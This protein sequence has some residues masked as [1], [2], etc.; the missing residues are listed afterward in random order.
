MTKDSGLR[1]GVQRDLRGKFLEVHR[2]QD[3]PAAQVIREFMRDY[4][5]HHGRST[6]LAVRQMPATS[7]NAKD[8][9]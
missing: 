3:K 7:A 8:D 4:V 2:T 6:G 1:I 9:A 5:E